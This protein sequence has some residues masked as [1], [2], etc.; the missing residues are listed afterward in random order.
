[1]SQSD[2]YAD[3]LNQLEAK[4]SPREADVREN[5]VMPL[6]KE[7]LGFTIAEIDA[8]KQDGPGLRPDY[9][10]TRHGSGV[11]D[12]IVEA[13]KLRVDLLRRTSK[14]FTSSPAGQLMRYL[15]D[16]PAS[17]D[18]TW[19]VATNGS[20]WILIQRRGDRVPITA[21]GEPVEARSLEEV[22]R[23]LKPVR[24][25]SSSTSGRVFPARREWL[26]RVADCQSPNEFVEAV[27]P[28]SMFGPSVNSDNYVAWLRVCSLEQPSKQRFP[29]SVSLAC[30]NLAFPDGK[31]SPQDILEELGRHRI[32]GRV[33]GMAYS[34]SDSSGTRKCR[35]FIRENGKLHATALVDA[36]LPGSRAARQIDMLARDYAEG[37]VDGIVKAFSSEALHRRFHEEISD[38]F[39][40]TNQG[41]NELAHLI[42]VMFV[43]LLQDRGVVP[44][45]T[46]WRP[47]LHWQSLDEGFVH[48]HVEWVIESVL[49]KQLEA[50][51]WV[52]DE[53]RNGLRAELPFLNG[54]LF[55]SLTPSE[56]PAPITNAQYLDPKTGLY[57]ILGRFDWTLSDRTGYASES[58]I[59][60]SMLGDLFERLVLV[61]DGPRLEPDNHRKMP[62]GTYYTPQDIADEMV[63]DAFSGW[64]SE[65]I[66]GGAARAT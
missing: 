54:S 42:R 28:E 10:C 34:D 3:N 4:A 14:S 43:W 53:W 60:A 32:D 37:S 31:M 13:K 19:G 7:T 26:E 39:L 45:D 35:G 63:V 61:T 8:E 41:R 46:L 21:I 9:V 64:I 66:G 48:S 57:S 25:R 58:A 50:R 17:D 65:K 27:A 2:W 20:H 29:E 36:R 18:G 47:G 44:D 11:A 40:R 59:D 1:M 62:G 49:A 5:L 55:T 22:W 15:N 30:L 16:Y 23:L 33:A 52:H 38:W 12:L 51:T 6:L 24:D 56:R